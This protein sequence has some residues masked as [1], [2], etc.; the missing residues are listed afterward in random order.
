[1]AIGIHVAKFARVDTDNDP[2][3]LPKKVIAVDAGIPNTTGNPTL[4]DY[5]EAEAGDDYILNLLTES[6]VITISVADM[7]AA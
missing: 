1:M 3:T 6:S 4:E 7:N 5:L 2:A